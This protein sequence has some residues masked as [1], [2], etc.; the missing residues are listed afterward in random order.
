MWKWDKLFQFFSKLLWQKMEPISVIATI[1]KKTSDYSWDIIFCCCCWILHRD[2]DADLREPGR[3]RLHG[4][5]PLE[6]VFYFWFRWTDPLVYV[7]TAVI[8][9]RAGSV[10]VEGTPARSIRPLIDI[11]S[12]GWRGIFLSFIFFWCSWNIVSVFFIYRPKLR[13]SST[14]WTS[15][16][17]LLVASL[18]RLRCLDTSFLILQI[19]QRHSPRSLLSGLSV[20]LRLRPD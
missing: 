9:T 3:I 13:P 19:F 8:K 4:Q 20:S 2:G 16:S 5:I 6:D 18:V 11:V 17:S 7:T 10:E 1:N 15:L 14:V 12:A